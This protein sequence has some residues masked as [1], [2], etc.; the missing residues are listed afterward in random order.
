MTCLGTTKFQQ[1]VRS[2]LLCAIRPPL[3]T[4]HYQ[5]FFRLTLL[6]IIEYIGIDKVLDMLGVQNH[7]LQSIRVRLYHMVKVYLIPLKS[8]RRRA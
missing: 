1:N 2:P 7:K 8:I 4:R 3:A 6:G 5:M